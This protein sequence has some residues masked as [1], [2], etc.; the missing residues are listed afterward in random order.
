MA[1]FAVCK[2]D[3]RTF[4]LANDEKPPTS[5]TEGNIFGWGKR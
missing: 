5:R 2:K 1:G 3:S 4:F